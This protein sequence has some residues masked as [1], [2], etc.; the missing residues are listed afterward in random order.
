[1]QNDILLETLTPKEAFNFVAN[2]KYKDQ[3][4]K[5]KIIDDT[6]KSLKLEKC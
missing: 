1:M 2:F 3:Q 4:V 5:D 6:I